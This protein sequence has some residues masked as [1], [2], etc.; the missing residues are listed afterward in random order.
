MKKKTLLSFL[1]LGVLTVFLNG[2]VWLIVG[3]V[4]AV[5]GYTVTRD[6]IQ[7]E[8]DVK[9]D[10]AWRAAQS[11]CSILGTVGNRDSSA[12][13]VEATID[14]A[15]VRVQIFQITPESIRLKVKA[16]RGIFPRLGMAQNV[17][18]KIV[19]QLM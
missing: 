10:D 5:G 3:G 7:G 1:I 11:V 15:K 16:R 12:G 2:C 9:F 4:G 6:T 8:Y 14:R 17:F 13:T 19:Q 18:V